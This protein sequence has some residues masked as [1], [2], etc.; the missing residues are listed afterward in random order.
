MTELMQHRKTPATVGLSGVGKSTRTHTHARA[1]TNKADRKNEFDTQQGGG[2]DDAIGMAGCREVCK[3]IR[4]GD[5][6]ARVSC[7]TCPPPPSN[8]C[9]LW[10]RQLSVEIHRP[11][12]LVPRF[13]YHDSWDSP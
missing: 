4:G 11:L 1:D 6:Y 10:K 5:A 7:K 2:G 8:E 12:L 13:P 9:G 3:V